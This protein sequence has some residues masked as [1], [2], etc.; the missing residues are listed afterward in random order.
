MKYLKRFESLFSGA[1]EPELYFDRNLPR[2]ENNDVNMYDEY[3]KNR[4]SW[5]KKETDYLYSLVRKNDKVEGYGFAPVYER[6]GMEVFYFVLFPK[7]GTGLSIE[8]YCHKCEDEVYLFHEFVYDGD[9]RRYFCDGFE[10][11]KKMIDKFL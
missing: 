11:L 7:E 4:E 3:L 10:T 8:I 9:D 2:S 1:S 5:T 6:P